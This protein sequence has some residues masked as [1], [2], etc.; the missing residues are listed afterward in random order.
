MDNLYLGFAN[1]AIYGSVF[2]R[3]VHDVSPG[4]A[5]GYFL[6]GEVRPREQKSSPS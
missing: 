4:G 6:G 2:G 1:Y 3:D 5:L